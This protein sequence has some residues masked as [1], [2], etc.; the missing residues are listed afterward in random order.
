MSDEKNPVV[1]HGR[2]FLDG[3]EISKDDP[4]IPQLVRNLG[5]QGNVIVEK[6]IHLS[7]RNSTTGLKS[8]I[9]GDQMIFKGKVTM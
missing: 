1:V 3:V 2:V 4:R 8:S 9:V 5:I 7:S 6:D